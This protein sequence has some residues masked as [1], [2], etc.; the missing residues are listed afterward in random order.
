[1]PGFFKSAC[2]HRVRIARPSRPEGAANYD[3]KTKVGCAPGI[4]KP[5]SLF[6]RSSSA[7]A[8]AL[9]VPRQ[10]RPCALCPLGSSGSLPE[11]AYTFRNLLL[12]IYPHII[13][14]KT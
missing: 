8:F 9:L 13:Y 12:R 6:S 5:H 10:R 2:Q 11:S 3:L 7:Q 14:L 4:G 1:M